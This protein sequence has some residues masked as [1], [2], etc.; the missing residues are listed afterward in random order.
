MTQAVLGRR[1]RQII[2]LK[3]E[4]KES[5][6]R[7]NA[8]RCHF[9]WPFWELPLCMTQSMSACHW[10]SLGLLLLFPLLILPLADIMAQLSLLMPDYLPIDLITA[11][12]SD[13]PSVLISSL[14]QLELKFKFYGLCLRGSLT[15]DNKSP[16]LSRE[17]PGLVDSWK[18][19]WEKGS[20]KSWSSFRWGNMNV[21]S[22]KIQAVEAWNPVIKT[23]NPMLIVGWQHVQ[24]V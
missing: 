1:I 5:R 16:R 17:N 14:T 19:L 8:G 11:N 6:A 15:F 7:L 24:Y 13:N 4:R 18:L 2:A 10:D 20:I 3:R 12:N 9:V 21:D 23:C 22:P